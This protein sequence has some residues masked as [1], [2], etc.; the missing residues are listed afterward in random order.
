MSRKLLIWMY[1]PDYPL[2]SM[3]EASLGRIRA[4]LPPDWTVH[5]IR[6]P[7]EARGDGVREV[8]AE[9][10]E[11]VVDA[12]VY[13]GF[14]IQREAFAAARELRWVHSG[15]GGVGG[16]LFPELAGS[17]V[18]LTN[19]AGIHAGPLAEYAIGAM[20]YFSRGFDIALAG[21]AE[22][23]WRYDDLAGAGSPVR[24]I[25]GLTVAVLG[26]GGIGEAVGRRAAALGL[27][28]LALRRT[29]APGPDW[30][31]RVYAPEE[32]QD[33]LGQSDF[34]VISL[35][36]TPH[37]RDLL[38]AD[39]LAAM[40]RG[41]VLINLSRG[42]IVTEPDLIE[43]L[44]AGHLRGAALDVFATEPLPASS[45]LWDMANVLITPHTGAVTDRFWERETALIETNLRR[46]VTGEPLVN[47]VDKREGY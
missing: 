18:L 27:R 36:E 35:P 4:A 39:E 30:V 7:L 13:M 17:D 41:S 46:Y 38:G 24:E 43:S 33:L 14:G 21:K 47:Q 5:S 22:R 23:V 32:L 16:S 25:G 6:V 40:R 10:L 8:P 34:V 3:P 19:S 45:P 2:W 26:I 1:S 20:V 44:R 28:V 42:R 15:A 37:T 9:L 29:S 11:Q 31:D 12:E